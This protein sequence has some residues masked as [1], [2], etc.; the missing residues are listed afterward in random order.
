[1]K[2]IT[3]RLDETQI[4]SVLTVLE[5]SRNNAFGTGTSS[6]GIDVLCRKDCAARW[7]DII[8]MLR[9]SLPENEPAKVKK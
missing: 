4:N 2:L 7:G 3:V 6:Y 5:H 1:M 9:A 8:T